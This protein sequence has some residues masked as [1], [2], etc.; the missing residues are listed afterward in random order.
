MNRSIKIF[1]RH[2]FLSCLVGLSCTTLFAQD[3]SRFPYNVSFRGTTQPVGVVLPNTTTNSASFTVDGLRLTNSTSQF[4]AIALD[5]VQFN[6]TNGLEIEFEYSM[7]GGTPYG[8]VYGDGISVFLY[9]ASKILRIGA[10]GA[11]LGYAYNR[12]I[13]MHSAYHAQGLNGGYLGIGLD[14]FG[15][16]KS[17]RFQSDARVNGINSITWARTDSHVTLRGAMHPTGLSGGGQRG[18]GYSGYPVL[19]T[20]ST[21]HSTTG[22]SFGAV[23]NPLTGSYNS[24]QSIGSTNAFTLRPG[25]LATTVGAA[26]YRKAFITLLPHILGGYSVTVRIQHGNTITTVIDKYHYQTSFTYTENAN[27]N[28]S[29]TN[30]VEGNSAYS[31]THTLNATVPASFKIGF[32]ASTGAASQI[33]LIRDLEVSIPYLPIMGDDEVSMCG[34]YNPSL[35]IQPFINDIVYNGTLTGTPTGGNTN[36]YIDFNSFR[37]ENEQ[38]NPIGTAT[39]YTQA[40]VGTWIYSPTNGQ[41]TFTPVKGYEGLATINYSVKGHNTNGGPFGQDI[42][43]SATTTIKVDVQNCN[44]VSNPN[45]PATSKQ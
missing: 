9:D 18:L 15:N 25:S 1:V 28:N 24:L 33:Q 27:A 41:V 38:G 21:R 8:G 7:Y 31:T 23:L 30:N 22:N 32:A 4:G 45:L 35:T 11:G 5:G 10:K 34:N 37:F 14:Q 43:R 17:R 29:T 19:I 6:S 39:S 3:V 12:S 13:D 44:A 40:N 20:Q 2:I 42:Y 36:T 16:F 26:N